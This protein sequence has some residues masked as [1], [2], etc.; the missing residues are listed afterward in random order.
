MNSGE[1]FTHS[2]KARITSKEEKKTS[3]EEAMCETARP[4]WG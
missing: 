4:V 1:C 3:A 2:G